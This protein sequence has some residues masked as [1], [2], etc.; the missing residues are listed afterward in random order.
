MG[1]KPGAEEVDEKSH[2]KSGGG[3]TNPWASFRNVSLFGFMNYARK[4]WDREG[5]KVPAQSELFVKVLE[6][7]QMAWH[8]IQNAPK[9][10]LQA[11]W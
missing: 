9:D 8:R 3:F 2:H 7:R 6:E 1:L 5:S 11:T 4:H 10:R